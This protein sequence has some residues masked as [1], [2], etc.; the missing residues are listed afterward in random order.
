MINAPPFPSA[1]RLRGYDFIRVL[2]SG[3]TAVV[4][5]YAQHAPRRHV[6]VKVGDPAAGAHA[7][8][9]LRHEA[10]VMA[11]LPLHPHILPFLDSGR[12][13]D[14]RDYIVIAYAPYGTL[15]D[16]LRRG[17]LPCERAMD[18]GVRLASGLY[19][20]HRHGIIHH[21]IK[22]SN[23]LIGA[24]EQP[25]LGDFGVSS[26]VY[27]VR[28]AGHSPPWAAPEV[29]RGVQAGDEASDVYSLAATVFAMLTGFSPYEHGYRP[30]SQSELI[31]S[32]LDEPLPRIGRDDVPTDAERALRMAL[33]KN[34]GNRHYSA[35][36]FARDLQRAQYAN[37]FPPTPVDAEG[38]PRYPDAFKRLGRCGSHG[39]HESLGSQESQG[40]E[41]SPS[42]PTATG[43]LPSRRWARPFAVVTGTAA[44]TTAVVLIFVCA[45]APLMDCAPTPS[46][47]RIDVPQSDGGYRRRVPDESITEAVG[48]AAT[49]RTAYGGIVKEAS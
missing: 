39:S 4:L 27:A 17:P 44:A 23:V 46:E 25:M 30:R 5:L 11:R 49:A 34:P 19:V 35:L 36:E 43:P 7:A 2:G 37:G 45:V 47:T 26:D 12:T 32:I 33:D 6:A 24:R 10:S 9:A 21:D 40:H 22:P 42:H 31:A 15:A 48:S 38:E 18:M 29:L 8:D 16:L 13:D 28:P 1:P 14:G 41:P 3:S 20:A